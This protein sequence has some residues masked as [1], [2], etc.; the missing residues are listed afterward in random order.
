MRSLF[1]KEAVQ[2]EIDMMNIKAKTK[3]YEDGIGMGIKFSLHV[4]KMKESNTLTSEFVHK[5]IGDALADLKR[6]NNYS[7]FSKGFLK[8]VRKE[9]L[10]KENGIVKYT[11][12]DTKHDKM[13]S[14][15]Q[16]TPFSN[17]DYGVEVEEVTFNDIYLR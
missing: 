12:E 2:K 1:R 4:K 16:N 9:L 15:A 6:K 17:N 5:V 13:K 8:I 14:K 10:D 11:S 7:S 3:A